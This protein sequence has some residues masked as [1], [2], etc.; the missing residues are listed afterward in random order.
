[1]VIKEFLFKNVKGNV[2]IEFAIVAPFLFL[3]LSG[4]MNFGLILANQHKLYSIVNAGMLYAAGQSKTPAEVQTIMQAAIPTMSP[5]T[6]TTSSFCQCNGVGATC[7]STCGGNTAS[8]YITMTA[9]SSVTLV[10]PDFIIANPFTTS[11]TG[12]VRT[13]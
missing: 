5:L 2:A 12:K 11:V 3:L 4:V 8:T 7:G 9:Q 10:A 13:N 6:I 1:M